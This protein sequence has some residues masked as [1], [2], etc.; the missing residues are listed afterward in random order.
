MRGQVTEGCKYVN[1]SCGFKT[2]IVCLDQVYAALCRFLL[3]SNE[4]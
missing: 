1:A 3:T 2:L 4:V